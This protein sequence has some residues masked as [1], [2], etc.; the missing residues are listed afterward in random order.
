[1]IHVFLE[2]ITVYE[3]LTTNFKISPI[4][5]PWDT[6]LNP[7]QKFLDPPFSTCDKNITA[8]FLLLDDLFRFMN[9][10]R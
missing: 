7:T 8:N 5:P 3:V 4:W 9:L 6:S 2:V 1:M 10:I